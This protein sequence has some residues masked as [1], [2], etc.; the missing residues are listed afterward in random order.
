[1]S[2]KEENAALNEGKETGESQFDFVQRKIL[3]AKQAVSALG[4]SRGISSA[5]TKLDEAS[6]WIKFEQELQANATNTGS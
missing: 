5:Q 1:M 3:E 2:I 4:H 6:M